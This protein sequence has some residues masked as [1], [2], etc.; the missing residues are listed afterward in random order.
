MF[1]FSILI[2]LFPFYNYPLFY[3]STFLP[4]GL[5]L[6]KLIGIIA[7]LNALVF[8]PQSRDLRS[9]AF[10][11]IFLSLI[12]YLIWV[13][14]NSYVF[15]DIG[16]PVALQSLLAIL[17]FLFTFLVFIDS[18]DRAR[19]LIL[20]YMFAMGLA[21]YRVYRELILFSHIYP[22]L[23][24]SSTFGD[25]NYFSIAMIPPITLTFGM[26][27]ESFESGN[28]KKGL[29]YLFVLAYYLIPF[30]FAAS[31]GA[32]IGLFISS[33]LVF[34]QSKRKG[35]ILLISILIISVSMPL[36]YDRF[37]VRFKSLIPSE[38]TEKT[39]DRESYEIRKMLLIGGL[40]IIGGNWGLGIG[41][42]NFKKRIAEVVPALGEEGYI[43]H[44]TYIEV[45]AEHGIIGFMLFS[46]TLIGILRKMVQTKFYRLNIENNTIPPIVISLYA[47]FIG[48]I[49]ASFFLSV[50]FDRI[51][52]LNLATTTIFTNI[53][54]FSK[55]NPR[56]LI[57]V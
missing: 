10:N 45:F 22:G 32:A 42:G 19:R 16:N 41:A 56:T 44:N 7:A 15:R 55:D 29:F 26:I 39:G 33:F 57:N 1:L 20:L 21:C 46:A 17:I 48:Y 30:L 40:Q 28:R 38:S 34:L 18:K 14:M 37:V 12:F 50:Q 47:S 31:R 6:I 2:L 54:Q 9:R 4:G 24:P 52:Y 36:L 23:R 27:K 5:S 43:A 13:M 8:L 11:A 49:I 35:V 53:L 3:D 51:F 25:P